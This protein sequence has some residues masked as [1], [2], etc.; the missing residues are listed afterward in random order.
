V[1]KRI[2]EEMRIR[3]LEGVEKR[4]HFAVLT[5]KFKMDYKLEMSGKFI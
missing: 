2:E 4:K 5:L 3:V 1:K